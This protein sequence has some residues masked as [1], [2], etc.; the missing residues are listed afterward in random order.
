MR[1]S[2]RG[3]RGRHRSVIR[4]GHGC[5]YAQRALEHAIDDSVVSTYCRAIGGLFPELTQGAPCRKALKAL[6]RGEHPAT[7]LPLRGL[8]T[9]RTRNE[10]DRQV[11]NRVFGIDCPLAVDRSISVAAF[12]LGDRVVMSEAFTALTTEAQR[13]VSMVDR[14][15]SRPRGLNG[16][17]PTGNGICFIIP[18]KADRSGSP[19]LHI[20]QVMPNLTTGSQG[21]RAAHFGRVLKEQRTSQL[22]VERRLLH[23]LRARGYP[24]KFDGHRCVL[25]AV[26]RF[27]LELW[28]PAALPAELDA[29][30][31]ALS[32]V[33]ARR[34][35]RRR[36]NHQ[37]LSRRKKKFLSTSEWEQRWQ[38]EVGQAEFQR[39]SATYQEALTAHRAG[40]RRSLAA[41]D[42]SAVDA[43]SVLQPIETHVLRAE[44]PVPRAPREE[45][46]LGVLVATVSGIGRAH[47]HRGDIV[48]RLPR[49]GDKEALEL[50]ERLVRL[51][52]PSGEISVVRAD[53]PEPEVASSGDSSAAAQLRWAG[54][55][56]WRTVAPFGEQKREELKLLLVSDAELNPPA[57]AHPEQGEEM[58]P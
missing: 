22:R 42:E 33:D 16:V 49:N 2:L 43:W 29:V 24:V 53:Q 3:D 20:H 14:R 47:S 35:A 26:P 57:A 48:L 51:C 19:L 56:V 9:S 30:P 52:L 58:R 10:G 27:L 17:T 1:R 36:D 8:T 18:E 37:L 32:E 54:E 13:S 21:Y 5:R 50:W 46:S 40:L 11:S 44:R 15:S 23:R 28:P 12:V 6:L 7:G 4:T 31:A 55:L 45:I 25:S 34:L 38:R 39:A 41:A